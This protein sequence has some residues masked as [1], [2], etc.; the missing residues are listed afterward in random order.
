[1]IIVGVIFIVIGLLYFYR[2]AVIIKICQL[3]KQY[4]VNEQ[5]VVLYG[6]KIGLFLVLAGIIFV[7]VGIQQVT[8]KNKLYTAYKY[9][10]S[11][12]F[13]AAEQA[14]IKLLKENPN[15]VEVILLLGK[16]YFVTGRYY[17][18]KS[19]FLQV[20]NIGKKEKVSEAEKY[21]TI[22]DSKIKK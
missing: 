14:C 15:N 7:G 5:I 18:A 2:Q 16:I 6:K 12:N 21:I 1:M 13:D 19:L 8:S 3:L 10:Y 17:Q 20:K 22:I 9:F 11:K 4:L